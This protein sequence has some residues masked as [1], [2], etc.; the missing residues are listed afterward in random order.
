MKTRSTR[1][2]AAL[3]SVLMTSGVAQAGMLEFEIDPANSFVIFKVKNRDISYVY[4]R[5]N[6]ITGKIG[7]NDT[8]KVSR[9]DV[10]AD[11]DARSVDTNERKRDRHLEGP[12]FFNAGKFKT[13]SFKSTKDSK[14][15]DDGTFEVIGEL[16]LLGVTKELTVTIEILGIKDVEK[17]TKRLGG[18]AQFTIKRS[19]FGMSKMLDGIA[20]EVTVVVALEAE[21]KA[22][23]AG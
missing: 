6:K 21:R 20:D 10:S 11:V 5:F 3:A 7:V 16:T 2:A 22:V 15:L 13:I 18:H 8:K 9:M 19:D 17:G 12:D 14:Q 23:A 4:G 1:M